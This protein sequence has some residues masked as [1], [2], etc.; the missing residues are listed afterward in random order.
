MWGLLFYYYAYRIGLDAAP[1]VFWLGMGIALGGE[2]GYGQYTAWI[3]GKFYVGD[4]IISIEPWIGY[5]W[6]MVCGIGWAPTPLR[7]SGLMQRLSL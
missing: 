1:V 5:L 4:D 2:L 7:V 3:L 6:F